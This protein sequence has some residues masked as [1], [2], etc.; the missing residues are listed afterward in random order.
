MI[1]PK[2]AVGTI[3]F[4]GKDPLCGIPDSEEAA[5]HTRYRP[6]TQAVPSGE[7]DTIQQV[8]GFYETVVGLAPGDLIV[9]DMP[10]AGRR[11]LFLMLPTD[12]F[13]KHFKKVSG[14]KAFALDNDYL[15]LLLTRATID[16]LQSE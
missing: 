1:S 14:Q 8:V 3:A 11:A 10:T 12:F 5:C 13:E 9:W 15:A 7:F 6:R 16:A 4:L 2:R